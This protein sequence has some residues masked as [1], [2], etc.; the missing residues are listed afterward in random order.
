[1]GPSITD[2]VS[3]EVEHDEFQGVIVLNEL[4]KDDPS[5]IFNYVINEEKDESK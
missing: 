5:T 4:L 1:M 3:D 2:A